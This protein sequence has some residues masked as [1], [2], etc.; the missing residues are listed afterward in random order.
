MAQTSLRVKNYYACSKANAALLNKTVQLVYA[1]ILSKLDLPVS[2]KRKRGPEP[3]F[4]ITIY[5][6]IT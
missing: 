6:S 4:A 5:K 2:E 3:S 1:Q